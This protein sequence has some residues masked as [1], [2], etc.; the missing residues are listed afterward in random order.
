MTF[1]G[2][3]K[4][5]WFSY[6]LAPIQSSSEPFRHIRKR[7][8]ANFENTRSSHFSNF[9]QDPR[10]GSNSEILDETLT[11]DDGRSLAQ[12]K[13]CT[14]GGRVSADTDARDHY[15][16]EYAGSKSRSRAW[17]PW[18]FNFLTTSSST[19][20]DLGEAPGQGVSDSRGSEISFPIRTGMQIVWSF[21]RESARVGLKQF[22]HVGSQLWFHLPPAAPPLILWASLPRRR[23]MLLDEGSSVV[24]KTV[25]PLFSNSFARNAALGG[26]S[27]AILSWSHYEL[28]R[29]RLQTQ[30]P[31]AEPYRDVT[32]AILPPFLPEE[33]PL[34]VLTSEAR[35]LDAGSIE[36]ENDDDEREER[37]DGENI[38]PPKPRRH[39]NAIIGK[40]PR[41][42]SFSNTL[43]EW[44]RTRE[45]RA[46]DRQNAR[47][48]AIFDELVALQTL[49][50]RR[51]EV[52]RKKQSSN[53]SIKGSNV[54]DS[55]D[56]TLGY[57]LVTG[58]SR[59]IG[60]AIAVE[61]ARW[62]IPLIL[63]A[64][65]V[66]RL[67]ALAY[68]IEACYGVKCCV[69]QA[70]LAQRGVAEKIYNTTC[71]AGLKVE[72]LINNAGISSQGLAVDIPVTEATR[73]IQVNA[74]S[75]S[76]LSH[77]YGRDMKDRRRGRI[78]VVSS[79]CAAVAGL[80]TVAVYA[81][82]K[83]FENTLS[84]S[85]AKELEPFGVGVTCLMP[86]AVRDT[87]FRSRGNGDE[88]LCWKLPFY[89]KV[90]FQIASTGVRA[91]LRGDTECVVGW[92]NR[93]FVKV[94]R[95]ILPQRMH[96]KIAEI[97]WSPFQ[98]PFRRQ[99]QDLGLNKDNMEPSTSY[100]PTKRDSP[101]MSPFG[102]NTPPLLLQLEKEKIEGD[103]W[104]DS[105]ASSADEDALHEEIDRKP[106]SSAVTSLRSY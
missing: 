70:D 49:K 25:V 65:D 5:L 4:L 64:R 67:T 37:S 57:A 100:Q 88:A 7:V 6:L 16:V 93:V 84:L 19:E 10:D 79:I 68:D 27:L 90:P 82:T 39:W 59:G 66:E 45:S 41:P 89:P 8:S 53:S 74:L 2:L 40:T 72:I 14:K 71:S 32:R 42:K 23:K 69:L 11:V 61:L 20:E 33:A 43:R 22:Q 86:G 95:P 35:T 58:A 17:P 36:G 104:H 77:L 47:R 85:M 87:S 83:A 78:L 26:L 51:A 29:K 98:W 91:M 50:K 9:H 106:A 62:E 38:L 54:K 24:Y 103:T 13:L 75:V 18:P 63:V 30:L 80:P 73:I 96:N 76:T 31:L 99:K 48:I 28:N 3:Y 105:K 34:N 94:L 44:R 60:R 81:A 55:D 97:A 52:R 12:R 21:A 46:R 92:Q 1:R 102:Y 56:A 101:T 15:T